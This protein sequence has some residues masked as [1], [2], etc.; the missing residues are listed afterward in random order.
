MGM[1]YGICCIGYN[2][3]RSSPLLEGIHDLEFSKWLDS[4]ASLL[5]PEGIGK[6]FHLSA[7]TVDNISMI[8]PG[9]MMEA[10]SNPAN[11]SSWSIA[12]IGFTIGTVSLFA[13]AGFTFSRQDEY[14]YGE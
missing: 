12:T 9:I 4:Y 10:L 11:T 3:F 7:E 14:N 6:V 2:D 5:C 13:I 8:S 1:Y